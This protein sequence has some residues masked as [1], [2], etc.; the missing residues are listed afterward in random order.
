[1]EHYLFYDI[2]TTEM[3]FQIV[4]FAGIKTDLDLVIESRSIFNL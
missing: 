3:L 4:Q 2:E 1:M